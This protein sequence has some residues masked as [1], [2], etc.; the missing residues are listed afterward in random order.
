[1]SKTLFQ[2]ACQGYV[3]II[4]VSMVALHGC[5]SD[6]SEE[7]PDPAWNDPSEHDISFVNVASG[8]DLEIADWGGSGPTMVF[9]AGLGNTSHAFDDFA[10]R[11]S[12]SFRVLAI[13]RRGFGASSHPE[14]GYDGKTLASD[15]LEVLDVKGIDQAIFLGHSIAAVELTELARSNADRVSSL[16]YLDTYCAIPEADSLLSSLFMSLPD[17]MPESLGPSASDTT[18]VE[19]YV[20]YVHQSRGVNIP[21]ADIRARYSSDGWN[22]EATT[23]FQQVLGNAYSS[24]TLCTDVHVPALALISQRTT[25]SQEEPWIQADTTSW[26][27][28][29]EFLQDYGNIVQLVVERFPKLISGSKA[30][31][32]QGGHHWIFTSHADE[33]ERHIRDFLK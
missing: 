27:A 28:Q 3:A 20:K 24:P 30:V 33:V 13:T 21:D 9:L 8:V 32:V 26:P 11:F 19:A 14:S 17:G 7:S 25:I 4:L 15:V 5:R 29:L 18:T 31:T 10:P 22:E 23:E 1:M 6:S 16:I 12:D 2:I